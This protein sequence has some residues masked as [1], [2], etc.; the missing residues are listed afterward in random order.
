[1]RLEV[2]D[3]NYIVAATTKGELVRCGAMSAHRVIAIVTTG[4]VLGVLYPAVNYPQ[5]DRSMAAIQMSLG[6]L[7]SKT[8]SGNWFPDR[9]VGSGVLKYDAAN[10]QPGYTLYSVAPAL[11]AHLIDMSGRELHRW[12][13]S[14]EE[15]MPGAT[16]RVRTVFGLL[17]PQVEVGHLYPNGDLLLIYA[18]TVLGAWDTR[19]VKVDKYSRILWNSQV[20]A[21]H[22]IAVV[23]DRIYAL[24]RPFK[25]PSPTSMIPS[26]AGMP[27]MDESVSLLDSQGRVLT[28]HSILTALAKTKSL[29]L[30]DEVPF[31]P[32]AADA[33]HSNSIDVLTEQ[34]APF[35]P[36]AKPGN[37]LLSLRNLDM[38]V[39]M[40]LDTDSI[41]WAL[42]GS[43]R[44]QHDAKMLPDG[45]ILLFDNEGGL[46]KHGR[47]RVLEVNPKTGGIAWSYNGIDDDPLDSGDN[48]GGAARLT[49]GNILINESN[50][51]RVL[52]V[53]P[54]GSVVWEYVNPIQQMEHGRILIASLGLTVV[55]YEPSYLNFL[56]TKSSRAIKQPD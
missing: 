33:L 7:G 15:I 21:H 20:S 3:L 44:K 30:A 34:T 49:G 4:V 5:I 53:T 28:T 31:D 56:A 6:Q 32:R 25:P 43:W 45:H 39:V 41:V 52:E 46:T 23:G 9:F 18:Q 1:M 10:T 51:G 38:L 48:R 13:V 16:A 40:D 12:S 47:S 2:A 19:L 24:T 37:V 22:A 50:A 27:Y 55:R 11:S 54:N 8:A 17:K 26:L 29:R 42:R 14:P 36:G 35:I